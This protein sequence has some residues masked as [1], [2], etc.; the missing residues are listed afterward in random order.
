VQHGASPASGFAL[1]AP[2]T[3]LQHCAPTFR[4]AQT[5]SGVHS[6][7]MQSVF[8]AH[9]APVA[10]RRHVPPRHPPSQQSASLTHASPGPEHLQVPSVQLPEQQ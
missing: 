5:F 1:H 7:E 9:G 10:W 4:H 6:P 3:S 8:E 2:P